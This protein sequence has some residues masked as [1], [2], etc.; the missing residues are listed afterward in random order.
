MDKNEV[1]KK[2]R[3][4]VVNQLG[5]MDEEIKL[6]SKFIEDLNADSLDVVELVMGVEEDFEIDIPDEDV[7]ALTTMQLAIEYITAKLTAPA[8]G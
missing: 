5:L 2:L 7:E 8:G 3:S 4:I 6:E 1:E